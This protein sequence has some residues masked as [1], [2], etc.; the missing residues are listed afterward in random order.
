MGRKILPAEQH[1]SKFSVTI[2]PI[3]FK[4]VDEL[5]FNKSKYVERLILNDLIKNKQIERNIVL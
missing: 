4:K 2:N 5:H 3:L 1:K